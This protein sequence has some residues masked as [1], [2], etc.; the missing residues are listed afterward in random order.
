MLKTMALTENLVL[1]LNNVTQVGL[2]RIISRV[3]N[4]N[5]KGQNWKGRE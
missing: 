1:K 3:E 2:R 4:L 5:F